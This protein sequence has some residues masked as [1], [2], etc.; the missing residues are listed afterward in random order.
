MCIVLCYGFAFKIDW[1]DEIW[2]F[3]LMVMLL[4]YFVE[5]DDSTFQMQ[6]RSPYA[7]CQNNPI[8]TMHVSLVTSDGLDRYA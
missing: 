8:C 1:L 7:V 2:I 4:L 5:K 6:Y 3:I